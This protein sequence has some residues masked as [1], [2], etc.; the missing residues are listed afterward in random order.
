[1]SA[2][3]GSAGR[4]WY[5]ADRQRFLA[6]DRSSIVADTRLRPDADLEGWPGLLAIAAS[7]DREE[8]VRN[9]VEIPASAGTGSGMHSLT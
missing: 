5:S 1:M 3:Q 2:D 9:T 4:A 7:S 6:S 8:F